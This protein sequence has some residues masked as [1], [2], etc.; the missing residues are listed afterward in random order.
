MDKMRLRVG[1][2][3]CAS[4]V[5]GAAAAY[6]NVKLTQHPDTSTQGSLAIFKDTLKLYNQEA[7]E[8]LKQHFET[9]MTQQNAFLQSGLETISQGLNHNQEASQTKISDNMRQGEG[10]FVQ[11][12]QTQL[13]DLTAFK[14]DLTQE[15]HDTLLAN[16][17]HLQAIL[18]EIAKA[19]QSFIE[20]MRSQFLLQQ[21]SRM[22]DDSLRQNSST[23]E[24][25][26]LSADAIREATR[27]MIEA[28]DAANRTIHGHIQD[29]KTACIG[30]GAA[31]LKQLVSE[32]MAQISNTTT[33]S[34]K[35]LEKKL[36]GVKSDLD[37]SLASSQQ[38]TRTAEDNASQMRATAFEKKLEFV[39][40]SIV[41]MNATTKTL[42]EQNSQN[43]QNSLDMSQKFTGLM[44]QLDQFKRS[45][46]AISPK[47]NGL[48]ISQKIQA[49]T[50][51]MDAAS[52]RSD[53]LITCTRDQIA[54]ITQE[55]NQALE[56]AKNYFRKFS[57]D[58]LNEKERVDA[59]LRDVLIQLRLATT[60]AEEVADSLKTFSNV[61]SEGGS[62]QVTLKNAVEKIDEVSN[63]FEEIIERSKLIDD[64]NRKRPK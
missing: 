6:A 59:S 3:V 10:L 22:N 63:K 26:A 8:T 20:S 16:D 29:L 50:L 18:D 1:L 55:G 47:D 40:K 57:A 56:V 17:Q 53:D 9:L 13:S 21:Q 15:V 31:D 46:D 7:L 41:D 32:S 60:K 64:L 24:H 52:K 25:L 2:Y 58:S 19:N 35:E 4:A 38:T 61:A 51:S 45:L 14:K 37:E 48:E 62:A 23:D 33:L 49:A 28:S 42:V 39:T 27:G 36:D 54:H 12:M 43:S 44:T 5:C 11:H 34:L 30:Q